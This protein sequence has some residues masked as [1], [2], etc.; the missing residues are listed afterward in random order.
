MTLY[1]VVARTVAQHFPANR[2]LLRQ[3]KLR[4]E[5]PLPASDKF[6]IIL[7]LT[8]SDVF[9][10]CDTTQR[11]GLNLRASGCWIWTRDQSE[12]K[13]K[14]PC[15]R[16]LSWTHYKSLRKA[17]EANF[18]R[19][20]FRSL[21]VFR[22]PK[23]MYLEWNLLGFMELLVFLWFGNFLFEEKAICGVTPGQRWMEWFP[24]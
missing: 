14:R 22:P 23:H 7:A 1:S 3:D 19:Q 8:T 17:E 16:P 12:L 13:M 15:K 2:A 9:V 20:I 21:Q 4:G 5:R 24:C 6:P 11:T 18:I 10:T